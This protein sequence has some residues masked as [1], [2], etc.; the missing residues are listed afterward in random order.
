MSEKGSSFENPFDSIEEALSSSG[1][2]PRTLFVDDPDMGW[3]FDNL[4]E[5]KETFK[6]WI[7]KISK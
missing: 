6:D 4:Y 5:V 7:E 2:E 1:K 3:F